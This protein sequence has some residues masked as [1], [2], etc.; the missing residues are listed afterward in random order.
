MIFRLVESLGK[1]F[2]RTEDLEYDVSDIV[3]EEDSSKCSGTVYVPL[4]ASD[5]LESFW[6]FITEDS[7]P[8]ISE[9]DIEAFAEN[10]DA[11]EQYVTDNYDELWD[12]YEDDFHNK[13]EEQARDKVYDNWDRYSDEDAYSQRD[14]DT[15]EF[16]RN[17]WG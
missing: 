1:P 6:E 5:I 15:R 8:P 14:E 11:W 4:I 9:T 17:V 10:D 3:D 13:Y 16:W 7:N 2:D 12:R